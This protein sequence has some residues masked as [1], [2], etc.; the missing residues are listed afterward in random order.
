MLKVSLSLKD[1]F[2]K[3]F[4]KPPSLQNHSADII[5]I[6]GG[7]A[8]LISAIHLS[9]AGL[10]VTLIEKNE[11]PKHKVCGEYISNEV[12]AYLQY[13]DA[14]PMI[15]GAKKIREK[16]IFNTPFAQYVKTD[17]DLHYT[18][19]FSNDWDWA[20]RLQVG[21]GL[22]YS[23]SALL[24]F[25]KQYIIGGSSSIR[26]FRVRNLGPGTYKPTADDQRFFQIIGGD[27]KFLLNTE[28]RIP[29]T[30]ELS[31]AIF[32]DAGNIWTKDTLIFGPAGKLTKNWYKELA[33]ATGFGLRFDASV[34]IIRAD[35]GMPLRKPYLPDGQR[36]VF[37]QIDFGSGLWRRENLILNIAL[38]LPF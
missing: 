6:G 4:K 36:W 26:G 37:K 23:N 1:T 33:V 2:Y 15:T 5:I 19:T 17:F 13:L 30:K 27:Y 28:I 32:V 12:L 35:L 22:P 25:A 14:D 9:K 24:P 7:L 21:I 8:G 29:I 31:T 3:N 38:G 18:R 16:K 10:S 34:L 20:N 11:Y